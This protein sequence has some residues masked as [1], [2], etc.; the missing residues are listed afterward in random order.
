MMWSLPKLILQI[1]GMMVLGEQ[2]GERLI[3][4]LLEA[5]TPLSPQHVD[6]GVGLVIELDALADHRPSRCRLFSP[7]ANTAWQFAL[8]A[9][10]FVF[11]QARSLSS[12]G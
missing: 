8:S 1:S 11:M 9:L 3:R 2:I 7:A 4:K 6:R 12:S 5:A 10:L